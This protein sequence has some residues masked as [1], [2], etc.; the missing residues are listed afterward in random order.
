MRTV[1]IILFMLLG[2]FGY[3]QIYTDAIRI[4]VC[5]NKTTSLIFPSAIVSI[6]RGSNEIM[7]QRSSDNILKVKSVGDS[8]KE[9]N[10]TVV[11]S[12]GKLFSFLVNYNSDPLHLSIHLNENLTV[13]P[14]NKYSPVCERVL[15]LKPNLVHLQF[16]AAKMKL[17]MLGWY[18]RGAQLY[19]RLKI[20]NR[21]QIGFDI[22]QFRFY[23]R[24]N[25]ISKRTASQEIIQRPVCLQGDTGTIKGHSARVWVVVLEKFTVPDDKHFA[26]EILERNGGRH[27]YLKAYNRQVMLAKEF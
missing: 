18:V 23:I 27:L 21:S 19:C 7:V 14:E 25:S 17:S 15:K 20:E 9:T 24:D 16:A 8:L 10:L 26:V 11:T 22:D 13:I 4:E 3:A 5:M 12:D 2:V 1:F 6:D